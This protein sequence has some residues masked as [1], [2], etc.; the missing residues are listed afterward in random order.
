M[1]SHEETNI[2]K[3]F[4]DKDPFQFECH[5]GVSCFTECCARLRLL[6]TPY[7]ILRIKNRLNISSD[8]FLEQYTETLFD[9]H[10]RFPMVKLSMR[11]DQGHRCPFVTDKGCSIYEDRPESCRLYPIGRASALVDREAETRE[12]YFIVGEAHCRGFKEK[13]QWTLTEW[14]NH[15]GVKEYKAM[16]DRWL[17]IV[18]SSKSLGPN[19]HV[20]RKHQMFFMASYNLD[21]FRKFLFQSKFFDHFEV[22]EALKGR[23]ETDDVSLMGFGFDWL[24]FSLFGDKTLKVK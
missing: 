10:A 9:Y 6:L 23:M 8:Q 20:T 7:D 19:D 22:D 5:A 3:P 16:N 2:F 11:K 18:T 17:S 1:T 4:S 21:K 12:K 14:L 15:E 13:K 24:K